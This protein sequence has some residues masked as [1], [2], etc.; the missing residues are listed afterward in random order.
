MAAP[1]TLATWREFVTRPDPVQPP[2]LD[3]AEVRLLTSRQRA[4][5]KR[6]RLQWLSEDAVFETTDILTL[7]HLTRR[8]VV[9]NGVTSA[10]ARRGLAISGRSTLGKS[11]ALLHLGKSH[12]IR[13]RK[14]RPGPDLQPVAY[15][16]IP[17]AA[18]PKTLMLTFARFL[19][20]PFT[21]RTTTD[22]VADAVVGCLTDLGTSMV[23]VDEIH[24]LQTNR[25]AG[26]EA[27]SAL[28]LFSERLDATF[29]YAGIDLPT[30]ELFTS[31]FARQIKGRIVVHEM[32]PYRFGT[33]REQ[34]DW[35]DLV[36]LCD[37]QIVLTRYPPGS[38][39]AHAGYLFDRTGGSIGTLR[40]LLADAATDA[41]LTGTE[42][43]NRA[44]LEATPTDRQ[45]EEL[46]SQLTSPAQPT[47]AAR[48]PQRSSR[49]SIRR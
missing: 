4:A 2:R 15:V 35:E 43:L 33:H 38:L 46:R 32:T 34:D 42:Q 25:A 6:A 3:A 16:V 30:S 23:L 29:L 11:T 17:P 26:A 40:A 44:A 45:A 39:T 22:I 37:E 7:N 47:K 9:R 10:T 8:T 14:Q 48:P 27:A 1:A 41:I 5:Y 28:K 12:E 24:N 13:V 49:R 21:E 20:L 36:A 31:A 19:G 18:T